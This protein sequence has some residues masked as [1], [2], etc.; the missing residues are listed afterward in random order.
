MRRSIR[1]G[2]ALLVSVLP[3]AGCLD[4]L[5]VEDEL[6]PRPGSGSSEPGAGDPGEDAGGP[7]SLTAWCGVE[8]LAEV[9]AVACAPERAVCEQ[10]AECSSGASFE[11][12]LAEGESRC[13]QRA[14]FALRRGLVSYRSWP[15]PTP[16]M[17]AT[18]GFVRGKSVACCPLW[19]S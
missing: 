11:D 16:R 7:P 3:L 15:R 6:R 10:L 19:R 9:V 13:A 5:G 12:C 4:W 1:W 18:T 2:A 8:R 14:Q 17:V